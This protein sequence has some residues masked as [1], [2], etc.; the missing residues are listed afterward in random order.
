MPTPSYDRIGLEPEH[1]SHARRIIDATG[2]RTVKNLERIL[3]DMST[4]DNAVPRPVIAVLR[5]HLL[6][7]RRREGARAAPGMEAT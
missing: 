4:Y 7:A 1:V 5:E 2:G 3:R 6:I